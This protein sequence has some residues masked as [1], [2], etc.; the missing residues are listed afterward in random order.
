[1]KWK[2]TEFIRNCEECAKNKLSHH[3]PYGESQQI[4]LPEV[5]WDTITIDFVVKLPR[6]EDPVTKVKYD[7]ILVVVDKLTK[8]AHLIPWRETGTASELANVLLKELVSQRGLPTKIISDQ[9]KL[10]TSKFWNTWTRQLGIDT[11]MST[12][13]HPQTDGQTERTNQTMEQYL[14]HYIN[15]R[16][17]DWV[18]LLPM[19]QFAYNDQQHSVTGMTLFF[20][21]YGRNPRWEAMAAGSGTSTNVEKLTAM[22]EEMKTAIEST[23]KTTSHRLNSKRLKGPTLERGDKVYLSTKNLRSKRLSKKLDHVRIGLFEIEKRTG[24][25]NY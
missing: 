23:Q 19:A 15:H 10:F 9:D 1:M 12:T 14:H 5:A 21:N 2:V 13:Y 20:A 8:Y 7:S 18:E 4:D 6:S 24:E 22:H 16:Q 11:R 3:K 17:D 25:V